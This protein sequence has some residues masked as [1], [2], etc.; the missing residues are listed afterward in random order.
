M[1]GMTHKQKCHRIN[2]SRHRINRSC[3]YYKYGTKRKKIAFNTMDFPGGPPPQYYP[4]PTPF[5]FGDRT[6][7]GA[8]GVVWS[9]TLIQATQQYSSRICKN[10]ETGGLLLFI[11]SSSL[12]CPSGA[13]LGSSGALLGSSGALLG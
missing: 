1:D 9:N 4:G 12:L 6:G 7:S 13:L 3:Y 2:Q 11:M 10:T 5:N 8:V